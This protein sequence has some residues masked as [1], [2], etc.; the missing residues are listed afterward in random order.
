MP[1]ACK[2]EK[3]ADTKH[4]GNKNQVTFGNNRGTG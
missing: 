3:E 2:A 4:K 1:G